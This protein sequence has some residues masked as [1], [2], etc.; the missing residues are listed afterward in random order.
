VTGDGF[1]SGEI[2]AGA[3]WQHTFTTPG[4]YTYHCTPHRQMGMVGTVVVDR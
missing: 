2:G 4:T 3:S 1:D